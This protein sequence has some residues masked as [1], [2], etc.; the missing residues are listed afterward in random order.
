MDNEKNLIINLFNNKFNLHEY[1]DFT[2]YIFKGKATYGR[3]L[4][5]SPK[6]KG[7][8]NSVVKSFLNL[9]RYTDSNRKSMILAVV[10]L[11]KEDSIAR[12]RT[13]QRNF[14]KDYFLKNGAD[15]ALVAFYNNKS[16]DWRL[17]FIKLDYSYKNSKLEE[18]STPAKRFSF[19]LGKN[20]KHHTAVERFMPLIL[21]DKEAPTIDELEEVF[22]IEVVTKE[23]FEKYCDLYLKIKN[24]LDKQEGFSVVAEKSGIRSD[25]FAKKLMGQ[26][27]FLYFLQKKGW[28]GVEINP[29][30]ISIDEAENLLKNKNYC[31]SKVFNKVYYLKNN[32]YYRNDEVIT[33]LNKDEIISLNGIFINTKYDKQWGTGDKFFIRSLFKKAESSNRNFFKDYL[34]PVFYNALNYSRENDYFKSLNCK[35]PFLNGGLFQPISENYDYKNNEFTIDNKLFSNKNKNKQ[36]D[37]GDGVLDIFDRYAFTI[38]EDEPLEKEV[39]VDPEMLGKVF[40]NLLDVTDRKKKG[41]FYTPREIVHYMCQESLINYL[42]TET[43]ITY[44]EAEALIRYGDILMDIDKSNNSKISGKYKMP[45]KVRKQAEI[46]DNALESVK[47]ADPAVGSG[48]F[49]L[50]MVNEIVRARTNLTYYILDDLSI[51]NNNIG[52]KERTPYELKKKTIKRCIHAVDIE[53]SAVDITKLRLWLS[54]VIE[55]NDFRRVT[56]LPNLDYNIM[57]GN[58]LIEEFE[59]VKLFNENILNEKSTSKEKKERLEQLSLLTGIQKSENL[60]EVIYQLEKRIEDVTDKIEAY[61]LKKQL[62]EAKKAYNEI[63]ASIELR[64]ESDYILEEIYE[65]QERFFEVNDTKEKIKLKKRIDSLEWLLIEKTIREKNKEELLP[66]VMEFKRTNSKPYFLWKLNFARVFKEKG[67]FDI[68][69][70]NPPY[71]GEKG[72]KEI[73][74]TIASSEFG[75][76]YYQGK[77]DLFY[78]FFHKA[79]DIN[80]DNGFIAFITT[81]YYITATGATKLRK[82]FKERTHIN[83]IIDFNELK[84]F[85]SA[86]GQHNMI[87]M[88]KKSRC[89]QDATKLIFTNKK[90]YGD[91]EILSN[92]LCNNDTDT[93]Y[94]SVDEEQLYEGNECYIRVYSNLISDEKYSKI[95]SIISKLQKNADLLGDICK[96]NSG[97]DIT[98]SRITKKHI[99][100]F[101]EEKFN[102]NEGVFV[103]SPE[104]IEVLNLD[105]NENKLIKPFFKNSNILKFGLEFNR[106]KL[107]YLRWE[108]DINKYSNIKNHLIKFKSILDDQVNRYGESYPWYALHR[109][110]EKEIFEAKEKILVPYRSKNNIFGFTNLPAYASRDVF[111][112]TNV[113]ESYRIKYLL[114]LLNSKLYYMWYYLKG[115]RKGE[116]LELYQTPLTQTPIR[117]LDSDKQIVIEKIVDE[118][119]KATLEKDI[120]QIDKLLDELNSEIYK[121]YELTDEEIKIVENFKDKH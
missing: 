60:L 71:V 28:L 18:D 102:F 77:M 46:I 72:N 27:V 112:I 98:I 45:L 17:S 19:L 118:I 113:S 100:N 88:L 5:F 120:K 87:T 121:Y 107:I 33:E 10:E 52:V 53:R 63:A 78:F 15:S 23:F 24:E 80:K 36:G 48:A 94:G 49:P 57:V 30:N 109:P 22:N 14:V 55:E 83:K 108:D 70:G 86:L 82:D 91:A 41:A 90:G 64:R 66:R 6:V 16:E 39:A 20:E 35:I 51:F 68:V 103:L 54:L 79:I 81:N 4:E 42:V 95:D 50:G 76:K 8:F 111:F 73:F 96:I 93:L 110:R 114:G 34:E 13:I 101:K 62:E 117:K 105:N 115:K 89:K 12:S 3:N 59:G 58:S 104:E 47:V 85:D 25:E 40:E 37:I 26:L 97:A 116:T 67:G 9:G 43:K 69:I 106:D 61:N 65:L 31:S 92:I 1:I 74:R 21:Q 29:E 2:Q 119:I 84:I 56:T 99:N 44:D 7:E 75:K 32:K 11:R 38:K